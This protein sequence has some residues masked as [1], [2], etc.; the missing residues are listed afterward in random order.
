LN[1]WWPFSGD[2]YLL[3]EIN[4]LIKKFGIKTIIETGTW[5]G[6]TAQLMSTMVDTVYTIE[7]DEEVYNT[8]NFLD[9]IPNVHRFLGDSPKVLAEILPTVTQ[10]IL[11]FLDA[12]WGDE[13]PLLKELEIIEKYRI[14]NSVIVIHDIYNPSH[15]DFNYD[16]YKGVRLDWDYIKPLIN[17]IY[18]FYKFYYN[19]ETSGD[20]CGAIFIHGDT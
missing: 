7:I 3:L 4:S 12:H 18:H 11:F 15:P 8:T 5:K 14:P 19:T 17:K 6:R 16:S 9:D 10:P 2:V 20:K 1:N 13:W